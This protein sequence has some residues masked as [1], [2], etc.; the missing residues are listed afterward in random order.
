MTKFNPKNKD[1]LTYGELL[2]P[3]MQI[4]EQADADQYLQAYVEW[5]AKQWM[6]KNIG[7]NAARKICL[8]NLG[9]FAAF[10]SLEVRE[11][12][13]RLFNGQHPVY[14]STSAHIP[15]EKE[16]FLAGFRRGLAEG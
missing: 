1:L 9:Y 7:K 5:Q 11:R 14:G 2:G 15:T 10:Y 4:T 8:A 3:A 13:E 16:I 12:V 6:P